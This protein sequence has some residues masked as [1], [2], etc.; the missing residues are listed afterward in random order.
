[1]GKSIRTMLISC[2]LSVICE[3][4]FASSIVVGDNFAEPIPADGN[5]KAVMSPVSLVVTEH[6]VISDIDV[7]L[8]ITHSDISDLRIKVEPPWGEGH[9]VTLKE[10]WI[11]NRHWVS[12]DDWR[13]N[14]YHTVFDDNADNRFIDGVAPYRGR[15][16][17][18]DGSFLSD[19]DGH[20]AFGVWM[21]HIYDAYYYDTGTLDSWELH[22]SHVPEP[23]CMWFFL[24]GGL[25]CL[26]R[27]QL[28]GP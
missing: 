9:C 28:R 13:V 11:P 20:D 2:F 10:E 25:M 3:P 1:M 14:M 21:L 24:T 16:R 7:Y 27:R 6:L 15:F 4:L 17:P 8:D 5:G 26:R 23:I 22:I 18:M 19:F 12:D